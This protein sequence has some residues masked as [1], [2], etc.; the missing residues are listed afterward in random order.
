MEVATELQSYQQKTYFIQKITFC[1][2]QTNM[3][4]SNGIKVFLLIVVLHHRARTPEEP[5]ANALAVR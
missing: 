1:V 4:W 2:S 5:N 3:A